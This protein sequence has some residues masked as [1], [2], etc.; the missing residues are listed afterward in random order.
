[1]YRT[2]ETSIHFKM[3]PFSHYNYQM[4]GYINAELRSP[5][6]RK[7]SFYNEL[8]ARIARN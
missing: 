1:M 2:T 4:Q 6:N 5:D 7:L 8:E 3:Q